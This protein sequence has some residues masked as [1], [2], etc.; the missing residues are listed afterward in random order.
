MPKDWWAM[1]GDIDLL[2]VVQREGAG[3]SFVGPNT[4]RDLAIRDDLNAIATVP[5]GLPA[6]QVPGLIMHGDAVSYFSTARNWG[7][8]LAFTSDGKMVWLGSDDAVEYWLKVRGVSAEPYARYSEAV[9]WLAGRHV[10]LSS[11]TYLA[12]TTVGNLPEA[13]SALPTTSGE[14][15]TEGTPTPVVTATPVPVP[16]PVPTPVPVA[17]P[18][19]VR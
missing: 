18:T 6:D 17:T 1:G 5:P 10:P 12:G 4:P 3:Y 16:A 19:P 9:S 11:A 2:T 7:P 8:A 13:L 14:A 15:V